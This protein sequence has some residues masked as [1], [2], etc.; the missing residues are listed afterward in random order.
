MKA[1]DIPAG[2]IVGKWCVEERCDIRNGVQYWWCL[3][4]CGTRKAV[5][6]SNLVS[7]TTKS[8][9]CNW[10][11][12][13]PNKTHGM[14][15]SLIHDRWMNLFTRC[16]NSNSKSYKDYGERGITIC[17]RW[18]SFENF[19]AD[20]GDPPTPQHSIDRK[21][22]NL[23]YSPENCYWATKLQQMRNKRSN[24]VLTVYGESL[25]LSEWGERIGESS[26]TIQKRLTRG[27][28]PEEALG[29]KERGLNHRGRS[30]ESYR[31][32]SKRI[33]DL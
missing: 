6:G 10:H 17:G 20:M 16:Y 2:T 26:I 7:Q 22:N 27:W 24:R 3:C 29:F 25:C 9:G 28:T 14:S 32:K 8:C 4:S 12:A 21:D 30:P 23:G 19:Y 31:R 18:F 5:N 1:S 11:K 33:K 15:G 13:P